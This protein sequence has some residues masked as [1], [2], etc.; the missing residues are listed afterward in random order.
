MIDCP[1]IEKSVIRN[2]YDVVTLF[3]RL[4]WGP[5]IHHGYWDGEE[6]SIVA[7]EQLTSKLAH[8]A[9][10]QP[11]A[12]VYDIGCG[13][14][15]SSRWLAQQLQCSVTGV[16]L[17]PI[18]RLWATTASKIS[19]VRPRPQFVCAD[20]ESVDLPKGQADIVWSI[21]CTEHLFD[22][23]TFFRNAAQWLKPGGR[24]ALCAWLAGQE[25][26]SIQQQDQAIAVCKGMFCPSLG[27]QHDYINWFQEAG[28]KVV[29]SDIWTEDVKRTWEICLRRVEKTGA[30]R[31]AKILGK[32][33]LLF[34]DHFEAI[35]NAYNS[36]AMEYG[37]FVAEKPNSQ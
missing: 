19:R 28:M 21:E 2:H 6:S 31:L 18:Q 26:L 1:N 8:R 14:G 15:G 24:F 22:K 30:R 7:Q 34:V 23:P 35:L 17:S 4:M 33:H 16:T 36:G 32:N 3:Y 9:G 12:V 29:V 13:M 25:P 10:I 11:G 27:N 20:A 5:H 37:V